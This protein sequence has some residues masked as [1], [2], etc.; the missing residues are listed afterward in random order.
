MRTLNVGAWDRRVVFTTRP[1]SYLVMQEADDLAR[2]MREQCPEETKTMHL[3]NL[4]LMLANTVEIEFDYRGDENLTL[5]DLMDFW[6]AYTASK[7]TEE[8]IHLAI[9]WFSNTAFEVIG[10]WLEAINQATVPV[11]RVEQLPES[12]MT[13]AEKGEAAKP[14]SPL[15]KRGKNSE[16]VSSTT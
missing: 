13:E 2:Q 9:D 7:L 10:T 1:T 6:Q 11:R 3:G 15:R 5:L 4:S 14:D 16:A 12:A 8:R